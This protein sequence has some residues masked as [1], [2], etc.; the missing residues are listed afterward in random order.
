MTP[1][2]LLSVLVTEHFVL[3]SARGA[4]TSEAGIRA[5][6]Y[7][8]FLTGALVALSFIAQVGEQFDA[9]AG[10]VLPA[11]FLLG[12]FT[13]VRL[14]ENSIEDVLLQRSIRRI[15]R[16][17]LALHPDA[18]E[19]FGDVADGP[20]RRAPTVPGWL[21]GVAGQVIYHSWVQLLFTAASMVA[22]INS[23]LGGAGVALL[24]RR[25]D[26]VGEGPRGRR[27][28]G[29]SRPPAGQRCRRT[30]CARPRSGGTGLFGRV[31]SAG[32]NGIGGAGMILA[33]VDD[34][35]RNVITMTPHGRRCLRQLD[36]LVSAIQD[37]LLAPLTQPERDQLGQ[38]LTR[39]LDHH[40]RAAPHSTGDQPA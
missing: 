7:L 2:A 38:L 20:G 24:V 39:L 31:S 11:L 28:R 23:I 6:L 15:R 4:A 25:L 18:A 37:E 13:Y 34:R 5:S 22:A 30:S 12:E 26:L 29:S 19:F 3:Q 9:F 17:Y 1:A 27:R 35:R 21:G 33:M 36:K 14:P 40:A 32:T 8:T 10:A 16:Y